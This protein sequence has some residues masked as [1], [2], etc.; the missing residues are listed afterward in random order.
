[1][2]QKKFQKFKNDETLGTKLLEELIVFEGN[3]RN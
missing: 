1:V 2:Y 3:V